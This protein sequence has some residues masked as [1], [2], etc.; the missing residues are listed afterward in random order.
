MRIRAAVLYE[1]NL[2]TPYAESMPLKIEEIELDKP[3]VGEVLI[4]V[5][6][7]GLCHSDLSVING[8]RPRK[9][10]MA[11]GH[12]AAGFVV[13]FGEGVNDL[14]IGDHVVCTFVPSCGHCLPCREGRPALCEPGAAANAAGVLLSG[15]RHLHRC[16]H[17]INH[18]LG[19]SGFADYA[20]VSRNSLVKVDHEIP[21]DL[22]AVF[23]CAV[24]TGVG[25]VVNTAHVNPG[26]IVAI[27]GLGGIGLSALLGAVLAGARQ[28]IAVDINPHKL[29]MAG[30]LGATA[31]YDSTDP[32]VIKKIRESTRGG[33]DYAFE[34]AGAV[35]A[36]KVAYEITRR[37]GMTVSTGLPH[38]Q[39]MFAFHQVTLAAEERTL[40]G[41][42]LG[43]C[44]PSR[45]IPRY[46][47]LFK[48]GRL[49]V[50]KLLS[51]RLRLDD[52]NQGFDYLAQGDAA[53]IVV[54][55]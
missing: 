31:V 24:I 33:V 30:E 35:A 12:E 41:S 4:Q 27:V 37:G 1:M 13:E 45:D 50:D 15:K 47:E 39:A 44:V 21:L 54:T 19:I 49:P 2:P 34:T 40:K 5:K 43:S 22:V 3:G 23:G 36:M 26:S 7:A 17:E 51:N 20:V 42:Y 55:I 16:D 29:E 38:P 53:R 32:E 46:I 9:M 6:A 28:I 48:R 8:S 10:P 18:H 11:L 52:I 25:A 14:S